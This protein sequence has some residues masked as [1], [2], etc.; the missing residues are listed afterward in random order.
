MFCFEVLGLSSRIR[1][2][3]FIT[4]YLNLQVLGMIARY[5]SICKLSITGKW[6]GKLIV[7][8]NACFNV[9]QMF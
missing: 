4:E 8:L 7:E 3:N 5:L 2:S 6:T 1:K 9:C